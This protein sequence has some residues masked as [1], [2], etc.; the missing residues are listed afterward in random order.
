MSQVRIL[1][2]NDVPCLDLPAYREKGESSGAIEVIRRSLA[3]F[4]FL[5]LKRPAA[6]PE[7]IKR[8]YDVGK[9]FFHLPLQQKLEIDHRSIDQKTF[10]DV[11]YY[12]YLTETAVNAGQADLKEFFHIGPL[13]EPPHPTSAYYPANAWPSSLPEFRHSFEAL[14]RQL[15]DSASLIL[16]LVGRATG[17]DTDRLGDMIVDGKHILRM[18]HYPVV[19]D[20][21]ARKGA[22]RAAPHTGINLI[23]IQFPASHPGLQFCT[24]AGEWVALDSELHEYTTINIGE[25]LAMQNPDALRPTLHQVINSRS[26]DHETSRW[27]IVFFVAPNP[28]KTLSVR[29]EATGQPSTVLA[30]DLLL[31]R[32]RKIGTRLARIDS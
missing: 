25:L 22:M 23:G 5:V 28:L 9:E 29:D 24:P 20:D 3:E 12:S 18:L 13:I 8:C 4:G 16:H 26:G 14:Y 1:H 7:L 27:A 21:R 17:M 31:E 32:F 19:E 11:G 6:D 30:G 2:K 15:T 10:G